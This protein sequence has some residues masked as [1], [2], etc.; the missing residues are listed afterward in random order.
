MAVPGSMITTFMGIVGNGGSVIVVTGVLQP[1]DLLDLVVSA[2]KNG[3]T[4]TIKKAWRLSDQDLFSIAEQG[5][6]GHA[7]FDF[8]GEG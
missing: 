8:T 4:V 2:K 1:R 7:V 5:R 3:G 6:G